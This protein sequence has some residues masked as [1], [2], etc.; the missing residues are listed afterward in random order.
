MVSH[1]TAKLGGYRHCGSGD[2][3]LVA[4]EENSRFRHYCLFLK[5]MGWKHT[6]YHTRPSKSSD[7]K[8]KRKEKKGIAK[9]LVL[10]ANHKKYIIRHAYNKIH[11]MVIQSANS[12]NISKTI[13]K[14]ITHLPLSQKYFH[15]DT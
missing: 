15:G 1:H 13:H 3:F 5:D 6:A 10:H 14:F 2:M 8:K 7:E 11:Y 9:R 4:E 12:A